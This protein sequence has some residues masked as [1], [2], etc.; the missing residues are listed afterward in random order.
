MGIIKISIYYHWQKYKIAN[1]NI[2]NI[3]HYLSPFE[4]AN[5]IIAT[6][7]IFSAIYF[8]R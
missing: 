2:K 6:K 1:N 7:F 4:S 5:R 8:Y 3:S